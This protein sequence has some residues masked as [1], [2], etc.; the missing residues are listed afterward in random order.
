MPYAAKATVEHEF[1]TDHLELYITFNYRMQRYIRPLSGTPSDPLLPAMDAL[2]I[3]ADTVVIDAVSA[4]WLDE[5]TLKII[6]D[7]F[8]PYPLSV[9]FEYDGP[10]PGL[11]T[12]WDKQWEP[13]GPIVSTDLTKTLWITG[14]ILVWFGSVASIPSGWALCNGSNGTPDLRDRFV[15]A[16]GINYAPGATGG[17]INHT[18]AFSYTFSGALAAGVNIVDATPA[19]TIGRNFAG[20]GGGTTQAANA[21]PPYHVLCYIMKL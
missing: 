1:V 4:S 12:A 11:K 8:S 7:T 3:V 13:F 15:L 20:G 14:M 16:A 2:I 10:D 19:G 5:W 6:S 18:H 17:V 21:L 9:S